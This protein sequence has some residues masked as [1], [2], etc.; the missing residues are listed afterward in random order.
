MVPWYLG[1]SELSACILVL[2]TSKGFTVPYDAVPKIEC[3][4]YSI[5][6]NI[7]VVFA[8]FSNDSYM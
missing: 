4:Y 2:T 7:Q 6:L 5:A 8:T 1:H 3:I